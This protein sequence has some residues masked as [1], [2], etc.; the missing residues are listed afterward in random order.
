[1]PGD[2]A[3]GGAASR[4]QALCEHRLRFGYV[5]GL[6][7]A[8]A[9]VD[10]GPRPLL[11]IG[12][13]ELEG[14]L[15]VPAA[16]SYAAAAMSS[17]ASRR[18]YAVAW[19]DPMTGTARV[20]W[21]AS[22]GRTRVGLGPVDALECL[23]DEEVELGA[24]DDGDP[25]VDRAAHELVGEPAGP[26]RLRQLLDDPVAS[27]LDERA[28]SACRRA[29]R[30]RRGRWSSNAA[31]RR[32]RARRRPRSP[33]ASRGEALLN[34]VAER[35]R[36]PRS[37]RTGRREPSGVRDL[38]RAALREVAPELADEERRPAR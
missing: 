20:K 28:T 25:V 35:A 16:V 23:A 32:R 29:R 37:S 7:E 6:R 5:P 17:S 27:G 1:M 24:P 38:E 31:R 12:D 30:P 3:L 14:G 18:L 2:A 15:S 21:W 11:G 33:G 34:D 36:G 22:S 9:E 26:R 10:L 4:V 8:V 19:R 13:A